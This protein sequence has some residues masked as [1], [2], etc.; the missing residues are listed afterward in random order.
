MIFLSF[1]FHNH[2]HINFVQSNLARLHVYIFRTTKNGQGVSPN[3]PFR[4][5]LPTS[6]ICQA[7]ERL[8]IRLLRNPAFLLTVRFIRYLDAKSTHYISECR[9]GFLEIL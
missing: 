6:F 1:K 8:I 7:I 4:K 3:G 5:Y 2:T 9:S